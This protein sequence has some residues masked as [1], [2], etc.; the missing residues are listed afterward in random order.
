MSLTKVTY[1]LIDGAG[2]YF[3]ERIKHGYRISRV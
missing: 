3:S 1:S 2:D